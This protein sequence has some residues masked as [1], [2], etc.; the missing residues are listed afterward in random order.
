MLALVVLAITAVCVVRERE[1]GTLERLMVAP[2]RPFELIIGKLAPAVII[3]YL[4]LGLMLLIATQLFNVPIRGSIFLYLG[5][6]FVYLLAEM[7]VGILIS[8][9]SRTQAQALPTIFLLVT[10]DG[11][12]AGF[13]TP[14]EMMPEIAQQISRAVPLRYF[15]AITRDLFAKGAGFDELVPH[16]IPL[17]LMSLVF[18]TTSTL[19][20]RR[21]LV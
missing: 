4:E 19:L 21:R 15:I 3:A 13:M 16:L 14:V 2:I 17:S 7:G 11:I 5:L 8:T 18:F 10:T 20:L 1:R 12:L 9:V 6:M